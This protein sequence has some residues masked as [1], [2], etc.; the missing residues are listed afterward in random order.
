MDYQERVKE[1]LAKAA[2]INFKSSDP[3]TEQEIEEVRVLKYQKCVY[4]YGAI[5]AYL[6]GRYGDAFVIPNDIFGEEGPELVAFSAQWFLKNGEHGKFS[7]LWHRTS[8]QLKFTRNLIP[9]K[10]TSEFPPSCKKVGKPEDH[11]IVRV[12]N[13]LH[14]FMSRRLNQTFFSVRFHLGAGIYTH[15]TFETRSMA[16]VETF[17]MA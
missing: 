11:C 12:N 13:G 1:L 15:D 3:V 14:Y 10:V 8:L 5:K 9:F 4:V 17:L 7:V 2:E 6:Q 16:F